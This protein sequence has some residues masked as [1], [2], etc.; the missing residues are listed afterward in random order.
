M[1]QRVFITLALL[2][3]VALGV[4]AD[5]ISADQALEQ[6]QEFLQTRKAANGGPRYAPG[7]TPK[8]KLASRLS[9]LYLF[10][11][12]NSGFVI[13]SNDD[14]TMPILGFS[15][16][17]VIDP[18]KIPD[19]MRVWL[20]GYADQIAYMKKNNITNAPMKA[21]GTATIGPLL[22]TKWNQGEPYN[23]FCPYPS[24][25]GC[26]ATAMAQVM[27][28]TE[29]K[30]GNSTTSTTDVIPGYTTATYGLSI[31]AIPAGETIPWANMIDDYS[32][33]Y[34]ENQAQSVAAI[35]AVCGYSVQ[36]DYTPEGSGAQVSAV[37][38]ALKAYFGYASTTQYLSRSYYSYDNWM[39][40]IYNELQQGRPVVYGGCAT[41]NAH[42]F[43]CDGYKYEDDAPLFHINWG[44]GGQ[45][46]GFFVLSV[47]NPQVQG[48]GGSVT[49]SAYNFGQEAVVGIQ[50]VGGTGTV[51][52]TPNDVNIK[53]NSVSVAESTIALGE[54]VDVTV[55]VTNNS[56]DD[57]DGD[58]WV[59]VDGY[60]Q[61]AKTFQIPSHQTMDCV[62]SL[63]PDYTG[64]L[65]LIPGWPSSTGGY[66]GNP[67]IN[68]TLT[69]VDA[70]PTNLTVPMVGAHTANINW[71]NG[72][73]ATTWNLRYRPM[74]VTEENFDGEISDWTTYDGDNDGYDWGLLPTSGIDG[75]KCFASPSYY[76]G[77]ALDPSD[78]LVTPEFN[79]GG[80]MSFFARG[81]GEK[82]VA[83]VSTNGANFTQ[84]SD[85]ITAT[86]NW[87]RYTLDLSGYAGKT[88][89]V[90]I[91]HQNSSGHTSESFLYVD[92]VVFY[93]VNGNWMTVSGVSNPCTLTGLNAAT[94]YEAQVQGDI[95]G[96]G[97]WSY[98]TN[99]TTLDNTP[100]GLTASNITSNSATIDWNA[101]EEV[102]WNLRYRMKSLKTTTYEI[103]NDMSITQPSM[104]QMLSGNLPDGWIWYSIDTDGYNWEKSEGTG[105][106]ETMCLRSA[107][108]DGT[109]DL[110]PANLLATPEINLGG[111]VKFWTRGE[112]ASAP[113]E[114]LYVGV[115]K[116]DV[117]TTDLAALVMSIRMSS[118]NYD[119]TTSKAVTVLETIETTSEYVEHDIDLSAFT[120]KGYI[121]FLHYGSSGQSAVNIDDISIIEPNDWTDID[122]ITT[123]SQGLEGLLGSTDYEVQVQ[124]VY[125]D[126]KSSWSDVLDFTTDVTLL[127]IL[128]DDS[129]AETKNS[130]LIAALQGQ[131]VNVTLANRTLYR[132]GYWNT[133]T[134]PFNVDLT[135]EACP[136]YGA[137]ALP[138]SE[139]SI[140]GSTLNLT[141]GN[142]VD[143]LVAGTP[144][145]IKWEAAATNIVN[146]VFTGV[147]IST[148]N[149][150]FT[151]GV[152]GELKV[153]F[154]G[155]YDMKTIDTENR[156]ILFMGDESGLYYPNGIDQ[157]F[158]GACRAYFMIGEGDALARQITYFNIDFGGGNIDTGIIN[159]YDLTIYNSRFDNAWYTIDGR[160]LNAK[161]TQRGVY[162]HNG[163]KM[164]IK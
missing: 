87:K 48:I 65:T 103:N 93:E 113:T 38:D 78:W 145:I 126:V 102:L 161:P 127:T 67:N 138:L 75:S 37:A 162:I 91:I 32:G 16:S 154:L 8:L 46:D 41:D 135:D 74:S 119:V 122:D 4:W 23:S 118:G 66:Y 69:V 68:T 62:I 88:G 22:T 106:N 60:P 107:S 125:N 19:N 160:K 49:I 39:S 110:T 89:F 34:T 15:D 131:T 35:M 163:K 137:T 114:K 136:L 84:L 26:V 92:D 18:Q 76:N 100:D 97:N 120:G 61:I 121:I 10:N 123:N 27:Y 45:S 28:Y 146:P 21:P 132:D 14:R 159:I 72:T 134:V 151:N 43:V 94:G 9:G 57:Y 153:R 130:A 64:T 53:V 96:G 47:L 115:M 59:L 108:K 29:T 44:W 139:A 12:D 40:L 155:T 25:T 17:G 124:A 81:E 52:G 55:N 79:L 31:N 58:V 20:Q 117:S 109:T 7:K 164:V 2:W 144:Y 85:E 82:F 33:S 54:S 133:L 6:A 111:R 70:T 71:T 158:I 98:S 116:S 50:K 101:G 143:E 141:F 99:F 42:A 73:G 140:T 129:D 157:T 13:V 5:D 128:N 80:S 30:A 86:S 156:S 112:D 3:A 36:M 148:D 95:N 56:S 152:E 51:T 63:T 104:M 77:S 83:L 90:A 147:T 24:P 1:R 105:R 142:S 150:D 11:V 149:N